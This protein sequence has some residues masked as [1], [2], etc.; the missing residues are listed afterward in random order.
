MGTD[1]KKG[2]GDPEVLQNKLPYFFYL[3]YNLFQNVMVC[4]IVE[5]II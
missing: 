5:V 3:P 4:C 2:H 1:S